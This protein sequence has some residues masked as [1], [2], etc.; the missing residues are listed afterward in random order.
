MEKEFGRIKKSDSVEII[1]RESEYQ[2]VLGIDIREYVTT[3]KY[4]GWTKSGI[5]IPKEIWDE[6]KRIVN[7]I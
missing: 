6:F 5:R 3:E 1:I 2:G 7:G 4:T